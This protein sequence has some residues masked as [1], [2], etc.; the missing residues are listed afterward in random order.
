MQKEL[1]DVIWNLL[2]TTC[3]VPSCTLVITEICYHQC[4][5]QLLTNVYTLFACVSELACYVTPACEVVM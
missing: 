4:Q 5:G 1:G 2:L 3:F